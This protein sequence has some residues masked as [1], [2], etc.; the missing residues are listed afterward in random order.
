MKSRV[1]ASLLM[2]GKHMFTDLIQI[3]RS[4]S[5]RIYSL[6]Y[7]AGDTDQDLDSVT[8]PNTQAIIALNGMLVKGIHPR[9]FT[10]RGRETNGGRWFNV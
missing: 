9:H 8:G 2:A 3:S 1:F 5:H 4:R 6:N 10:L 7:T